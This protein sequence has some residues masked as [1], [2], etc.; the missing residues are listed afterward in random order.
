MFSFRYRTILTTALFLILSA[1]HV[2]AAVWISE[3][4]ADNDGSLLDGD[5]D[6]SDWIELYNDASETVDLSGW[7]LTDNATNLTQWALPETEIT[8]HGFLIIFASDKDRSVAGAELHTNF[9]L[10]ANGEYVALVHPDG[11]SIE[12]AFS[13]PEQLED[14]SWGYGFSGGTQTTTTTLID[15]GA[16]CTA[17]VPSDSSDSDAWTQVVFD[18]SNWRNG[19]TGV[20]YERSSGYEDYIGLDMESELYGQNPSVYIRIPFDY[21]GAPIS[22]L[23]LRMKY[24]DGFVAYL[25]GTRIAS[26]NAPATPVWNSSATAYHSDA[27]AVVFQNIDI[28][29]FT[30]AL[31][32]GPNILSIQGLNEGS[33]SSDLLLLPQLEAEYVATNPGTIETV[34][35]GMLSSSTPG[36]ANGTVT[37]QGYCETPIISRKHGICTSAFEV[38]ISNRTEGAEIRYTTNG[39]TPTESNSTL[40]TGPITI[41]KTTLLRAS[42]FKPYHQPSTP[43]TQT[44][45]FVEDVLTQD[46]SNLQPYANWGHAGPDWAVDPTMA[47][48]LITDFDG[49]S[50]SLSEALLDIPTVSLVTDWD[51]WWSDEDGPTLADGI[52]PWLG[53][54]ADRIGQN[55]VRR[56]VS[57]EFFTADNSEEFSANGR[58][59]IVGGGIGG[60]SASRWKADKLSMRI[61]FTDKLKYPVYG[62]NAAR[63][64]NGLI[65]DAHLGFTWAHSQTYGQRTHPKYLTDAIASDLQNALSGKGAPHGRFV[66]LYLNG[67]YWGLY[68]LHERPDEHFAAEY[69]GG[70]NE[71]YDSV[72]HWPDDTDSADS[73]HDGL[74]Y[75]DNLTNGDDAD[76]QSLLSLSR[77]GL[78]SLENYQAMEARLD[79]DRLIDYLLVNFFFGNNDWAHKNWY[80]TH[81]HTDPQGKW[82]YHS[83]DVE[84]IIEVSMSSFDIAS[85]ITCDVTGKNDTGGPTEIHQDLTANEEYRLRFADHLHEFFF[86][87]GILTTAAVTELV[88]NRVKEMQKGM[89]GEAARWADN[90]PNEGHDWYEWKDQMVQFRDLY[91]PYRSDIVFNQLKNRGLYP[92]T[93]APE[94]MINGQRQHG[95]LIEANDLVSMD[96]ANTIYYTTDGSDPRAIGGAIAGSLYSGP[97]SFS[98][99]TQLKARAYNNGEWS[100]LCEAVFWTVEAPLAV[101][102][103]MYHAPGGNEE[104]FIEVRNISSA[105][106]RLDGYKIDG[107]VDFKFGAGRLD[108]GTFMLAIQDIDGFSAVHSTNGISIA[109]EYSGDFDNHGETVDLEFH[110][111]DLIRFT[112]S[113][114]RNWPQA[115]DGAGHSLVPIDSAIDAEESGSLNYGGNWRAS[116]DAGG[117]PGTAD[118]TP[119]ATVMLNEITAHTDTGEAPPFESNDQIELYNPTASAITL[120]GWYLSDDLDEP[121]KWAI[122][123]GTIVPAY[124]FILFDEDDFHP[125]RVAGFGLDKAGELVVLSSS[126]GVADVIRFK[127]QENGV[128]LGRY[129]DGSGPWLTTQL[130][131]AAPNQPVEES[132][133]ISALMYNPTA[134]DGYADGDAME[135]IQLENRSD[136]SVLFETTAG[137]WRIDGGVSFTFPANFVMP[138][139]ST[140]WLVSFDPTNTPLLNLFCSTYG[141]SAETETI[142]GPYT[143]QLSNEGERVALERPQDSDDPLRPLDISWVIVDELFYFDQS[144]WPESADGTGYALVRSGLSSWS[145]PTDSDTDADQLDDDWENACFGNLSQNGTDDPDHD[146]FNNLQERIAGTNPTD[147][148]SRF[149]IDQITEPSIQWTAVEGRTYSVYW[150][151]DLQKPFIQISAEL[152]YPQNCYTDRLHNACSPNFYYLSVEQ[153]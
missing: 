109:G 34:T 126:D 118:P 53:I 21:D 93:A 18:D 45:L 129:P 33:T 133:W 107:A 141:I 5:G 74:P 4:M 59:S 110:G 100:A 54:Y 79:I 39:S 134:P 137:A 37:Y 72:K 51:Y 3:I 15:S 29:A 1:S 116:T 75:N 52:T 121:Q 114:A 63:K 144:P 61:A 150:T 99:P 140:L 96:C 25:N 7:Y 49:N 30:N 146:G 48:S 36:T 98:Q 81:N 117:S 83:W 46:G 58:V 24:D 38:T 78:S 17:H 151:D 97:L 101:T 111:H 64:F 77:S 69:F 102:E 28:S 106:V 16:E 2:F 67:L 145:V 6:E 143:G 13:F 131:P 82:R 68:D 153:K 60:T 152:A 66:H 128:S 139:N 120:N 89:L 104:D 127:G 80:A 94:F 105:P 57:M 112:Y 87:E 40:Y 149:R 32:W 19:T 73:D 44:Y 95:G 135:Y 76:L 27:L 88:W 50:V 147:A 71:D 8:A 47:A 42:A 14:V 26:I 122:P 108:P 86:N 65:L 148:A 23:R 84:H 132:V 91:L 10:S 138:A 92:N 130:T 43:N 125:D 70:Q 142:L 11:S 124:G 35:T 41:N 55:A 123:D 90:T 113:D 56:P 136:S 103:L 119:Q 22:T 9:K 12:S 62:E 20:G 85:S 115:A 31:Y